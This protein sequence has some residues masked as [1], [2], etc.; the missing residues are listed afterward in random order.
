MPS[1]SRFEVVC[2]QDHLLCRNNKIIVPRTSMETCHYISFIDFVE[3]A[4]IK[5]KSFEF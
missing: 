3:I 4:L 2:F 1:K 5:I